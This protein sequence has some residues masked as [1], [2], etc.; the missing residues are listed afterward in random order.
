MGLLPDHR[1][2]EYAIRHGMIAPFVDHQIRNGVI[3]Y[4]LSSYGYD[5]RIA[6]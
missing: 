2:R 4:G 6:D 3:S 1:I 5:I